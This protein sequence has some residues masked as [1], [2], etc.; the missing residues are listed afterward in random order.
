MLFYLGKTDRNMLC[1]PGKT[2]NGITKQK[3]NNKIEL[4]YQNHIFLSIC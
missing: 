4:I 3:I 2:D 1:C